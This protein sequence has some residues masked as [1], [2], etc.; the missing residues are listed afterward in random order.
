MTINGKE[1]VLIDKNEII[2]RLIDI[3]NNIRIG[4]RYNAYDKVKE[5]INEITE[6]K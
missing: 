4:P 1:C 5:L 2:E 6:L 3:K